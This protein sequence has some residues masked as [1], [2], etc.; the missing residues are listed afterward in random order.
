MTERS[1]PEMLTEVLDLVRSQQRLLA[2]PE[3]LLPPNYLAQAI[4]RPR[5]SIHPRAAEE[6][7]TTW[8]TLR[9]TLD[10]NAELDTD[11]I[12]EIRE[13]VAGME[14]VVRYITRPYLAGRARVVREYTPPLFRGRQ[15]SDEE[16]EES[17][18]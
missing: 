17:E 2:S 1:L 13:L 9:D 14:P 7:F 3:D 15:E 12:D 18:S 11:T 4:G 10:R 5:S 6:L 16:E 8:N